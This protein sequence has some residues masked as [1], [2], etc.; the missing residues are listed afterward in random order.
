M[1]LSRYKFGVSESHWLSWKNNLDN[2]FKQRSLEIIQW[3]ATR[4]CNMKCKHCG[5]P[6]EEKGIGKELSTAEVMS[7]FRQIKNEINLSN[8]KF[9]TITGGEPFVR[10]DIWEVL[11]LLNSFGWT[12]TLQTN[13]NYFAAHPKKIKQLIEVGVRGMGIDLDGPEKVHDDLRNRAGHYRQTTELIKK[14]LDYREVL[15]LT[16]TTVVTKKTLSFLDKLWLEIQKLNPHRWRLLPLENIGRSRKSDLA[17]SS[18]EY[19]GL[20]NFIKQKRLLH[21]TSDQDVQTELGCIGWLG[22]EWEGWVRPYIWSCIAG[23]TCLGILCDGSLSACAHIDR[24]YIQGN[25]RTDNIKD[26]WE[27][28]YKIFRQRP[29]QAICK[30]CPDK[31]LC[32]LPMHKLDSDHKLRECVFKNL[33]NQHGHEKNH[34]PRK[35]GS[36]AP[37]TN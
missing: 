14:F 4:R 17:L 9:I 5:S 2:K 27:N 10:E 30:N 22:K 26:V 31:S 36:R 16:V 37:E 12:T 28:G 3:E 35:K 13:G 34:Q 20:L 8:F 23:R 25:V 24:A 21:I 19:E 15:H 7:A 32:T 29:G 18:T 11:A 33:N 1:E 6:Q